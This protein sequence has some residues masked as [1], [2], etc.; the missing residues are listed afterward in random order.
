[1]ER[2]MAPDHY[3]FGRVRYHDSVESFKD[4]T[5]DFREGTIPQSGGLGLIRSGG[6]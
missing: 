1:V 6:E 4:S 5:Y 3:R 2:T